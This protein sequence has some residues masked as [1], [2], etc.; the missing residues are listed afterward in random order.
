MNSLDRFIDSFLPDNIPK[1]KRQQLYDEIECH[2]L[3]RAD[4]YIEIGYDE[5]A[6]LKKS[7]ECFGEER[8]VKEDIKAEFNKLYRE[9]L[10]Y[11]LIAGAVPIALNL[12]ALLTGN[13]VVS[14][15]S[16][17]IPDS[18][19]VFVSTLFLC[20]VIL[21]MIFC[22]KK[23]F[24]KSLFAT[25]I[26]NLLICLSYAFTCYPQSSLY[27]LFLNTAYSLER[28]T[29]L[30]TRNLVRYWD[31]VFV[32]CGSFAFLFIVALI[33]FILAKK[34]KIKENSSDKPLKGLSVTALIMCGVCFLTGVLYGCADRYFDGYMRW[35]DNSAVTLDEDSISVFKEIPL[36]GSYAEV[37]ALLGLLGYTDTDDY[38]STLSRTEKK[39]FRYSLNELD[40][41]FGD[42]YTA[43]FDKE[44]Y[45]RNSFFFI[46]TDE[47]GLISGKGIGVGS[48]Y[49]DRY[50]SKRHYCAENERADECIINF[51]ALRKGDSKET[52]L[53][54][55]TGEYG[56]FYTAFYENENGVQKDYYRIHSRKS[57]TDS[58]PYDTEVYIQLW[59]TEGLLEKG[60]LEYGDYHHGYQEIIKTIP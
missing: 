31:T 29:P 24:H 43:F 7:M 16:M 37:R 4:F 35:F 54:K 23:G 20:I 8:E 11:A 59:F 32:L 47:N 41:F 30:M 44:N 49:E 34:A 48:E 58:Y 40:F 60:T 14:F 26:S 21:Q 39:M 45:R 56:H 15:H 57:E 3:D 53:S 12:I 52:V 28:L 13:Y 17:P 46:R 1:K 25:G 9:R 51:E 55:L 10:Y 22:Y 5:E 42:E 6:A 50:G 2:I 33:S 19:G 27:A 38:M 36:G 18:I